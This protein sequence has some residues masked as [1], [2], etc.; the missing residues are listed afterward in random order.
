MWSSVTAKA[1]QWA[2]H[3]SKGLKITRR[4]QC[5][6]RLLPLTTI[7]EARKGPQSLKN[8]WKIP[9]VQSYGLS[10]MTIR[11]YEEK[12][13][14]IKNPVVGIMMMALFE[15]RVTARARIRLYL[16][17]YCASVMEGKKLHEGAAGVQWLSRFA[18]VENPFFRNASPLAFWSI[19]LRG[20]LYE[21]AANDIP[22]VLRVSY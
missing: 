20:I 18:E 19:I 17:A 12:V 9:H 11:E 4:F 7:I 6:S 13:L 5:N 21:L 2:D 22:E 3:T 10:V 14:W 1:L 8:V 16:W 15:V